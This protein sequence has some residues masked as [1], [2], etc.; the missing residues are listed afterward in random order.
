MKYM[1]LYTDGSARPN[2]GITGYGVHGYVGEEGKFKSIDSKWTMTTNGYVTRKE[3][4]KHTELKPDYIIE[5]YGRN[6]DSNTNNQA[7]LDALIEAIIVAKKRLNPEDKLHIIAD[8]EYVV[9]FVNNILSG[10]NTE[11]NSNVPYLNKI[12]E[13]M[14]DIEFEF[15]IERV[16][17]HAGILG[18]EEADSLSNIG[19]NLKN[20]DMERRN[21]F[22]EIIVDPIEYW[23]YEPVINEFLKK[24]K[25]L[26]LT[27]KN[28]TILNNKNLHCVTNYKRKNVDEIGKKDPSITYTIIKNNDTIE[29]IDLIYN[30]ALD[31]S[32]MLKPYVINLSEVLNKKVAKKLHIYK[33]DY[34][35]KKKT[36][37]EIIET[38]DSTPVILATEVF[39]QSL[40]WYT[41]EHFKNLYDLKN[42]FDKKDER[43]KIIDIKDLIFENIKEDKFVLDTDDFKTTL[44]FRLNLPEPSLFTNLKKKLENVYLVYKQNDQVVYDTFI[45]IVT[46]D[47][48]WM[49]ETN[50]FSKLK[51]KKKK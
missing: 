27:L 17:G 48:E 19:R 16:D 50:A 14:S 9:R 43:L 45:Y 44:K 41:I 3:K 6:E 25:K 1:V 2:P 24:N 32:D 51:F 23:F 36:M 42:E 7:E 10:K 47:G 22:K 34:I 21:I 12:K 46:N 4:E 13:L 18:N 31:G 37:F 28:T 33:E 20:T 40:S 15:T 30:I 29:E 38:T 49:V 26:L 8:S 39:P 35:V 5:K 11:Y